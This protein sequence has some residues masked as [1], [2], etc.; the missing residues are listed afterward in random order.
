MTQGTAVFDPDGVTWT[1]ISTNLA[2]LRR[3]V[4]SVA[5]GVAAVA[6]AVVAVVIGE[7]LVWLALAVPV[8]ATLLVTA[9]CSGGDVVAQGVA[10]DRAAH[11]VV[12][13]TQAGS[14][15]DAV[16]T[17][18]AGGAVGT[19]MVM[20]G[21]HYPTDVVGGF[22]TA[23]ASVLTVA[24]VLD[25]VTARRVGRPGTAGTA[26]RRAPGLQDNTGGDAASAGVR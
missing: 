26:A 11:P 6:V 20:I 15:L 22:C 8:L 16:D 1:P 3:T 24:L 4:L 19:A 9:G 10:P 17:A 12:A 13:L 21:S 25:A 5:C 18:L 2:A 23:V 14:V 7:P